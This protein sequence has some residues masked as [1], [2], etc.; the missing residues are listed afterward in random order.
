MRVCCPDGLVRS[1]VLHHPRRRRSRLTRPPSRLR[2]PADPTRPSP[3]R[4]SALPA[5]TAS[6]SPATLACLPAPPPA[7]A[8]VHRLTTTPDSPHRMLV[9]PMLDAMISCDAARVRTLTRPPH[10]R[11]FHARER[12]RMAPSRSG[13]LCRSLVGPNPAL[14]VW[15]AFQRMHSTTNE[16]ARDQRTLYVGERSCVCDAVPP[17]PVL[18][19]ADV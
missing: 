2:I 3:R 13:Q 1:E 17:W 18:P 8:P 6:S 11:P 10:T 19:V 7:A 12:S 15:A 16:P 5:A 4:P 9:D 14:R